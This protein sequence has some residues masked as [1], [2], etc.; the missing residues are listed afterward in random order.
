MTNPSVNSVS[1][2]SCCSFSSCCKGND[3]YEEVDLERK[4]FKTTDISPPLPLYFDQCYYHNSPGYRM[5]LTAHLRSAVIT[6]TMRK[7][8][9]A[10]ISPRPET[11]KIWLSLNEYNVKTIFRF[12]QSF[13]ELGRGR[14]IYQ[15]SSKGICYS[16]LVHWMLYDALSLDFFSF[17]INRDDNSVSPCLLNSVKVLQMNSSKSSG[18]KDHFKVVNQWLAS[19][20]LINISDLTKNNIIKETGCTYLLHHIYNQISLEPYHLISIWNKTR[21]HIFGIK[22][23]DNKITFCDA[24]YGLYCFD[25][26]NDFNNWFSTELWKTS[27]Y[28]SYMSNFK[29]SSYNKIKKHEPSIRTHQITPL[30]THLKIEET[31]L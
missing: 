22:Y 9:E 2:F 11:R 16:L 7:K 10:A 17:L 15:D 23:V 30:T 27:D 31:S 4:K 3:N 12:S 21:G 13:G 14:A 29:I 5:L 6:D 28:S 20:E 19:Y 26:F 8:Y 18:V 25:S 1:M 24:N